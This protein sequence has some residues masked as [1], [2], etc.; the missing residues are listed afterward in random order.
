MAGKR[1]ASRSGVELGWFISSRPEGMCRRDLNPQRLAKKNAVHSSKGL[2]PLVALVQV[3]RILRLHKNW[4]NPGTMAPTGG[5]TGA[6]YLGTS[7][8]SSPE[9]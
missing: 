9:H 8:P 5:H 7:T 3:K 6:R 1:K 4:T 2:T